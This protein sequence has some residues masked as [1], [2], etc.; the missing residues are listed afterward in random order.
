MKGNRLRKAPLLQRHI[1]PQVMRHERPFIRRLIDDFR[2]RLS[3]PMSRL[4]FNPNQHRSRPRLIRLHGRRELEAMPRH[5][6]VIMIRGRNQRRRIFLSRLQIVQRRV[7]IQR[8]EVVGI[9]GRSVIRSPRPSNRELLK[10]QHVHHS[11][12]RQRRAE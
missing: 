1:H 5:H 7:R 3:R 9:I 6:A 2:N 11:H 4:G 12:Q 10:A 8:L